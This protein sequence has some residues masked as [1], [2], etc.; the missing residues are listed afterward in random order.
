MNDPLVQAGAAPFLA[1][2]VVALLLFKLRLG[3]LA[4]AAVWVLVAL[5]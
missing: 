1:G 2:F 5:T 3:G 4:A